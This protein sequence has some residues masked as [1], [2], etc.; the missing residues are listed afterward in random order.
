MIGTFIRIRGD[1]VD[2]LRW[3]KDRKLGDAKRLSADV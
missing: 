2:D 1:R 3:K